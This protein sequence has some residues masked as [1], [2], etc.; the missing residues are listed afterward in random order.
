[1]LRWTSSDWFDIRKYNIYILAFFIISQNWDDVAWI[2]GRQG[3]HSQYRYCDVIMSTT[4]SLITGVS[5]VYFTVSSSADQRKHQSSASLAFERGIHRWPVNSPHKGPVTRKMIPFDHV[6]M[7]MAADILATPG[8]SAS[9]GI[10]NVPPEYS[11]F[12]CQKAFGTI[13]GML[14][15]RRL[16]KT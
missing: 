8:T 2:P 16:L 5:I 1:M 9:A 3:S 13:P 12:R 11:M 14:V 6:I 15:K 10:D 4:A 7:T